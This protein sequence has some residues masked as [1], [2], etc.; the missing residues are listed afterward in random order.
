MS[1]IILNGFLL[2]LVIMKMRKI[3]FAERTM[4]QCPSYRARVQLLEPTSTVP[5]A[6]PH[7]PLHPLGDADPPPED[8]DAREHEPEHQQRLHG[9]AE[10]AAADEEQADA[11]EHDG[12][13]DPCPV[14]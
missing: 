8:R 9:P 2:C 6:L 13:A 7:D 1:N 3:M 4:M 5:A 11:A 12:R 10:D 14:R